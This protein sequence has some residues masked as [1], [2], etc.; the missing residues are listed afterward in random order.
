MTLC[1]LFDAKTE[2]NRLREYEFLTE[3]EAECIDL[4]QVE[5]FFKSSVYKRIV[6]ANSLYREYKFMIEY[7]Y[8]SSETIV[9]GIADCIFEESDGIVILD[10]KTDNVSDVNELLVRYRKQLEIYKYAIEKIFNKRVKECI[11]YSLNKNDY[12]SF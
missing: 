3:T 12:V 1:S 10:F 11:L 6:G 4:T 8:G 2:L 9:Q 7:P 5:K